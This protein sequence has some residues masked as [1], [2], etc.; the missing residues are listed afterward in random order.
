MSKTPASPIAKVAPH[1]PAGFRHA[2][3]KRR[4]VGDFQPPQRLDV[5]LLAK[6]FG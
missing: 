6:Q 1:R 3:R 5:D 2:G 4:N